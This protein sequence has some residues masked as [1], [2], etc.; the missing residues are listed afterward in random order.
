MRKKIVAGNWKMNLTL[1]EA[2]EL[3]RSVLDAKIEINDHT[4]VLF[5]A[6]F[7]YIAGISALVRD[8][9]NYHVAAQNCSEHLQ[10]AYT[11]EVSAGMIKNCGASFVIVGHSER[12]QYYGDNHE[13]I[14]AKVDHVLQQQ[15]QVV[16]CC[17][18]TLQQREQLKLYNVIEAQL[19][20]SLFHLEE[21][22]ILK[23]IIAYEPVW[24]IGTGVTASAAQAQEMHAYIRSL[25]HEKYGEHIA[26]SVS[27]VYGGSCNDKNAPELFAL[28][29]VDGGLIGGASL[30]A[31]SFC[32]IINAIL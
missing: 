30:K 13:V 31:E 5:G 27:I 22:D 25:L 28:P 14:C 23:C 21:E 2:E 16:F 26:S 32:S 18:E 24:A 4:H 29:D 1:S 12:R 10:G 7:P 20:D 9:G 8:Q 17:G 6:P 15:M 19:W 11:G 3:V